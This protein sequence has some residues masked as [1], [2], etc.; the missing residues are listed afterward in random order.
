MSYWL[1]SKT[2][3]FEASH[4]LPH[5]DGQCARLH[6]HSWVGKVYVFGDHLKDA[7][8]ESGMVMDYGRIKKPLQRL[9][10]ECL[11]H[12]HL[13]DSLRGEHNDLAGIENPTSEEIARWIYRQ[14]RVWPGANLT[15]YEIPGLV[16]VSI[17][18]T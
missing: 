6:G 18:E 7:P 12:R 1:L 16:A 17:E 10:E 2:F 3:R 14:L 8:P 13:N 15:G 4:Q 5:H 11:D 9:V